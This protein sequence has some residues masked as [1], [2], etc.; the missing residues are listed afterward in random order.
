MSRHQQNQQHQVM[1]QLHA[2]N[3][4]GGS[5]VAAENAMRPRKGSQGSWCNRS[6]YTQVCMQPKTYRKGTEIKRCNPFN[7]FR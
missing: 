7:L 3:R 4:S 2:P 1:Q 6:T 5:N